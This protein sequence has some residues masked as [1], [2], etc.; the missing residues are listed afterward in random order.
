[1]SRVASRM[2]DLEVSYMIGVQM[3]AA[4][5]SAIETQLTCN[6]FFG[7]FARRL[8]FKLLTLGDVQ[9]CLSTST[10]CFPECCPFG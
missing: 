2:G 7:F 9:S 4:E 1:M 3:L 8:V 6:F 10:K 5:E